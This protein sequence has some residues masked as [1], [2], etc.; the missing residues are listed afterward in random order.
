MLMHMMNRW[1]IR[2]DAQNNID[3]TYRYIENTMW[4]TAA[5]VA[6]ANPPTA[7]SAAR[8]SAPATAAGDDTV[9]LV[10]QASAPFSALVRLTLGVSA[11]GGASAAAAAASVVSGD[12]IRRAQRP[13]SDGGSGGGG[14]S[15]QYEDGDDDEDAAAAAVA[16]RLAAAARC[17]R[18][19]DALRAAVPEVREWCAAR[20]E[21]L[22]PDTVQLVCPK[23]LVGKLYKAVATAAPKIP[24]LV[25]GPVRSAVSAPMCVWKERAP[26]SSWQAHAGRHGACAPHAILTGPCSRHAAHISPSSAHACIHDVARP[27]AA[28]QVSLEPLGHGQ[29]RATLRAA[30]A[31]ALA[32]AGWLLH[33]GGDGGGGAGNFSGSSGGGCVAVE[34]DLLGLPP[35]A[36]G[37]A[38]L[39]EFDVGEQ[40]PGALLLLVRR[41]GAARFR[42]FS[43]AA[44]LS[45]ERRGAAPL[46]E[47]LLRRQSGDDGG[48]AGAD[49]GGGG[50]GQPPPDLLGDA[51]IAADPARARAASRLLEGRAC[52]LLPDQE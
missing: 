49:A 23:G 41:A 32:D 9:V 45:Q 15:T 7:F 26:L 33:S 51:E 22:A 31:A 13:P 8:H 25:L 1:H 14:A 11:T 36:Q 21:A 27:P 28:M 39:V 42:R 48:G 43:I 29:L 52:K 3:Q 47:V 19:A 20:A 6:A 34:A 10:L 30:A 4:S 2:F 24:G 44:A 50:G 38:A 40:E 18:L 5:A 46:P 37:T 35:G 17:A 12:A 16:A